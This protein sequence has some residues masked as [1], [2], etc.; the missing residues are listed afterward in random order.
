[1]KLSR[2][3][4]KAADYRRSFSFYHDILG[5]PL[6]NSWQRADSWGALFL[7]GDVLLEIIWYPEGEDNR[8]CNYIPKFPKLDIFFTVSNIE[9][10]H[11]RLTQF[12]ELKISDITEQP[13]GYKIFSLYDPDKV[14]V[15]FA[16]P[17]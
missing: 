12:S 7:C 4:I 10:Q 1:M 2:F 9:A 17:I 8:T 13:W 14:K 6:K 3:V 11:Q 15:V 16:Q 5:L